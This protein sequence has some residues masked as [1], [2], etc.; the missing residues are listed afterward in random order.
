MSGYIYAL[1]FGID[2]GL[3]SK[4]YVKRIEWLKE[5]LKNFWGLKKKTQNEVL[6][7]SKF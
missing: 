5:I 3:L 4:N 1:S 2:P 6:S 7:S